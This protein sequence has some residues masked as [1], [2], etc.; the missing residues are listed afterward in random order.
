MPFRPHGI[1]LFIACLLLAAGHADA[2]QPQEAAAVTVVRLEPESVTLTSTLPGRVAPSAEAEV[3]P[4]VNGIVTERLF[5]EGAHVESGD[6]LYR[7]DSE[8]YQASV[9]QSRARVAQADAELSAAERDAERI[10]ELQSRSVASQQTL[11][12]A[13]AARD[14]ASAALQLAKAQLNSAQ[15]DLARTTIRARL[16]GRIGLAQISQGA[17]V[18]ASQAAPLAVIRKIDPVYVDVTQSAAD[19]LRWRRGE[20]EAALADADGTVRLKLADGSTYGHTGRLQAAEP[21]VDPQTGVVTLRMQF[22]NPDSLLLPGMYVQVEMPVE[23]ARDIFLVPQEGVVRDRRGRPT[24]WVVNSQEKVEERTLSVLQDRGSDWVV[25][26]GLEP[27]DRVIVAGFQKTSPGATV[28][29]ELRGMSDT[30]E[31]AD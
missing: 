30:D 2:Q 7:I 23:V 15:I 13:L 9:R 31:T 14:A 1:V 29:A 10:E 24:A 21:K 6:A 18:T 19:L 8:T 5:T 3:R 26:S 25:E 20:T 11:D 22:A 12:D 17:L 27:G 16:S 28:E 4:Q